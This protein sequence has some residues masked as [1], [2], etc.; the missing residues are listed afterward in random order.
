MKKYALITVFDKSRVELLAWEL[1]K[2]G[3]TILSTSNTAKHLRKFCREVIEVSELTGFPEILDGRV[4]TLHPVIHAGILA[5]RDNPE[6]TKTL[7]ELKID[8]IDIVVVNLYPFAQT[9]RRENSTHAEIIENIDIGGPSL[10]RAAAKNYSNVL[11]LTDP[12]DYAEVIRSLQLNGNVSEAKRGELARKA[13]GLV[14]AYD[15]EIADFFSEKYS[16]SETQGEMPKEFSLHCSLTAP[17]RYGENPHQKAGFYQN[18][19]T[20]LQVLHGKELS[21]NNYLDIDSSF[22]AL[23]LFDLPTVVI[24]KHCNPCGIGSSPSLS[25]AYQKAFAADTAS[26]Y[27]GIVALNRELDA[28][29]ASLINRVFT[30]IIIAPGY[31]EGVLESLQKKKDRRLIQY[32]PA[33]LAKPESSFEIKNLMR[34]YLLQE[35]DLIDEDHLNWKAATKRQPTEHELKAMLFGWKVVSLLRSNAI[36][37]TG[38]DCVYGLGSGQTSRVDSTYLAIWKAG[39]YGH[40]LSN[41]ICASDGFF[42]YRDS[43]DELHKNGV[44]AIIQPGGSKADPEVIQACDE[45]GMTMVIT[46]IRHFRH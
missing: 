19:P 14:S 8:R 24:T 23:R 35:W 31:A 25:E 42:P 22:K 34:G 4:K 9:R 10:I 26:P 1:E 32:D 3:Y 38:E 40:D 28:E 43:V 21:F 37:L 46:G 17:L 27:G 44:R 13:F 39:K 30:E 29:T 6:H 15:A 45:Y 16:I 11:V 20:G 5:D 36:A 33:I 2:L 41:A 7:Q 12:A 18:Q